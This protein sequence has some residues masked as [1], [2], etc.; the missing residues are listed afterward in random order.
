MLATFSWA[1]NLKVLEQGFAHRSVLAPR[2]DLDFS[3]LLSGLL[4]HAEYHF[5]IGKSVPL[6][7]GAL[8][9]WLGSSS[10]L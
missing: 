8:G 7:V 2:Q 5:Y 10:L 4:N 9:L 3:H 1:P 6:G